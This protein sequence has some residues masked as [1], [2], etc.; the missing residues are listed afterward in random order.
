MMLNHDKQFLLILNFLSR[1]ENRYENLRAP[2]RTLP[3]AVYKDKLVLKDGHFVVNQIFC[4]TASKCYMLNYL[5][6][7]F[8]IFRYFTLTSVSWEEKYIIDILRIIVG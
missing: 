7:M 8:Q 5:F 4:E 1:L 6:K 3:K 2:T